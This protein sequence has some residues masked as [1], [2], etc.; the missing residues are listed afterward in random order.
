MI[1]LSLIHCADRGRVPQC[2]ARPVHGER[3]L[4]TLR[5]GLHSDHAVSDTVPNHS[6]AVK[7]GTRPAE[8][9]QSAVHQILGLLKQRRADEAVTACL[10]LSRSHP[11]SI[12]A[13]LL[14]GKARQMQG[15]FEDMLQLVETALKR[16]PDNV[17]LQLQLA[18]ASQFCGYHDRAL[19]QL[20]NAERG[21]SNNAPLLQKVAQSYV[22]SGKYEDAHRCYLRAVELD[23]SDPQFL[24]NLASSLIAVGDLD[25]AEEMYSRTIDR[26]PDNYEAWYNRSTLRRQTADN[27]HIHELERALSRLSPAEGVGETALCYALAKEYEDI[28]E[29]ER[30]FSCLKRGADSA[31]R[32]SR[33]DVQL[34]VALMKRVAQLFD[35]AYAAGVKRASMRRG[36]IFVLGLPRTGTTL[37]ERIVGSHSLVESM[38]EISDFPLTLN[39]LGQTSDR[40]Q[41]LETS[42][43]IDPDQLGESYI[44]SVA[45]RGLEAPYFLDKTPTNYLYLGLIA[46]ALPAA[47]VIHIRRHPVDSCL[48]MY[49]TLFRT[50]YPFSYDLDDLAEYYVAYDRLM[51]HWRTE[52]PGVLLDVSY[53]RLVENQERVSREIIAHCGLDWETACLEFDTNAAPVATASAAQVR[54]PVYRD[55]LMR[56]RRF[57]AQLAPLI[58]RLQK[59]GIEI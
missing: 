25:A 56:W 46:K 55:G 22:E 48:S 20:A 53:E 44:R 30:S 26:A 38:G 14:L 51:K 57:E 13:L 24:K 17:S 19:A 54:K 47:S 59:A 16:Q 6:V 49:R 52:F 2:A 37:V 7:S 3:L 4:R 50:G 41:L 32:R 1:P 15:R 31:R 27:N 11:E 18:G 9:Y 34:D 39:R 8:Q 10:A 36:P 45:S 12:D 23:G 5:I 29:D 58:E 33:Y 21:A 40:Q 42:A 28:G 43:R 35:R